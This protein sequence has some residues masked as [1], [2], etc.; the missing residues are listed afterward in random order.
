VDSPDYRNEL[1]NLEQ[2]RALE[3]GDRSR[4]TRPNKVGSARTS[5][6]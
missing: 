6:F 4:N 1:L 2:P 5:V 3:T